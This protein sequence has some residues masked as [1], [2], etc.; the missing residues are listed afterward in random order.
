MRN[1]INKYRDE[2]TRR[3]TMENPELWIFNLTIDHIHP[4]WHPGA[5]PVDW[6][7]FDERARVV[8]MLVNAPIRM[9]AI[10]D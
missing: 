3:M 9:G 1:C 5:R 4:D 8:D 6:E 10:N 2:S 7:K